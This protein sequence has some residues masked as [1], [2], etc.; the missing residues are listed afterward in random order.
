MEPYDLPTDE[1]IRAY[2]DGASLRTIGRL[3][4]VSFIPIRKRL[5]A[6]GVAL[7]ANHG[8]RQKRVAAIAA[9]HGE[10]IEH[11]YREGTSAKALARQYGIHAHTLRRILTDRGVPLRDAAEARRLRA[12]RERQ[13]R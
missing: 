7:R 8:T 2:R 1:I 4:G 3:Y 5:L 11:A 12:Q 6:E 9:E 13:Q 10:A